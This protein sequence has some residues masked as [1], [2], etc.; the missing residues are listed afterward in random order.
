MSRRSL[1]RFLA[2][3]FLSLTGWKPDGLR[4]EAR[5]FVLIA[6]PHTTNWDFPYLLAFAAHFD[7]DISW[8]GKDTLFRWPFGSV[9]RALGGVPVRRDRRENLVSAM[10]RTFDDHTD[11]GLVVPAE[12]TRSHVEYWKSGF[13]HIATA[14][15]VPIVMSYL[16]YARK[17]GGFGPAFMPTGD[18]R[19]DMGVIRAF[20]EGRKGKFPERFGHIRLREEDRG[21]AQAPEIGNVEQD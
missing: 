6:A 17:V 19:K 10:A 12:G 21:H 14:A 5:R 13:Y 7:V 1:R 20:Y 18:I 8:M 4:P 2:R 9:M 11:L 15:R 3:R 16:D